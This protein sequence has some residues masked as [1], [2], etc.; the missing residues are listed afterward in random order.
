MDST[1]T[2]NANDDPTPGTLPTPERNAAANIRKDFPST[3]IKS[4][5]AMEK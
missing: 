3:R 4:N 2:P 1:Q 5:A